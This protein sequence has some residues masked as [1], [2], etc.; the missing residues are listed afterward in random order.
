M[1]AGPLRGKDVEYE[2]NSRNLHRDRSLVGRRRPIQRGTL[3]CSGEASLQE[4]DRALETAQNGRGPERPPRKA[5]R[6]IDT[7]LGMYTPM[8]QDNTATGSVAR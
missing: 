1:G 4:H 7:P 3:Q 5:R 8:S 2:A 6:T